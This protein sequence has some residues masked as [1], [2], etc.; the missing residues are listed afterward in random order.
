MSA[1]TR[2]PLRGEIWFVRLPTDP[3][4]KTP[5]PV[6]IVSSNGRNR[7]VRAQTVLVVPLSTSIH[8]EV[9]THIL[10]SPGETGLSEASVMKAEDITTVYKRE[11]IEPKTGLRT[12]SNSRICAAAHLVVVS[13]GCAPA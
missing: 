13:M 4:E 1:E 7:N 11:L 5:R 8:K 10:L 2:A 6:V 9:P 3:L 12:I